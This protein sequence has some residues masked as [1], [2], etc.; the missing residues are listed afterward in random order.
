MFLP[1]LL[2]SAVVISTCI[3]CGTGDGTENAEVVGS[4]SYD[5][6]PLTQGSVQFVT[7][8]SM[9]A[10]GTIGPDGRFNASVPQGKGIPPGPCQVA[11]IVTQQQKQSAGVDRFQPVKWLIPKGFGSTSTSGLKTEIKPTRNEIKI[12]LFSNG[13]GSVTRVE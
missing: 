12:E 8:E 2:V 13:R 10:G 6:K 1:C 5:G 9:P 3:G 7:S 4:V 11:V